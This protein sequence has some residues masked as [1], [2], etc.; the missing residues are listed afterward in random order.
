MITPPRTCSERQSGHPRRHSLGRPYKPLLLG[1]S[2]IHALA[3][4]PA[5]IAHPA[6]GGAPRAPRL[7]DRSTRISD[8][9]DCLARLRAKRCC[10][11]CGIAFFAGCSNR[12]AASKWTLAAGSPPNHWGDLDEAAPGTCPVL[13]TA[14]RRL[15]RARRSAIATEATIGNTAT[16]AIGISDITVTDNR[17]DPWKES[18][19]L[20]TW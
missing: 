7:V 12:V 2:P 3:D 20:R 18:R 16:T 15:R 1:A 10:T 19:L 17:S 8:Y 5:R 4:R 6:C 9:V 14:R 13:R 11:D